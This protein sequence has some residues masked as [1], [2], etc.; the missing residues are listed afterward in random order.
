MGNRQPK[1][2]L[3]HYNEKRDFN[4]YIKAGLYRFKVSLFRMVFSCTQ[5][6]AS[7]Y[8]HITSTFTC[9]KSLLELIL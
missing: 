3:G 1:L 4:H 7:L 2:L 9:H 8:N 6:V 5:H